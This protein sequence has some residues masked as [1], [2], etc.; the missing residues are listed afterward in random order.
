[1]SGQARLGGKQDV[2]V[3]GSV[4]AANDALC[5]EIFRLRAILILI[6]TPRGSKVQTLRTLARQLNASQ[7]TLYLWQRKYL[8]N[9]LAGLGRS[10]RSDRGCSRLVGDD[11]LVQIIRAAGRVSSI[12][13][14]R[15]EFRALHP[16]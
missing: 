2:A 1:M 11:V 6:D 4:G 8:R 7:R 12:G 14:I 3:A 9:G 5:R 13:D 15:R 16:P 10:R